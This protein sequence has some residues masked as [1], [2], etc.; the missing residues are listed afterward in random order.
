MFIPTSMHLNTFILH[1]KFN[2]CLIKYNMNIPFI[3]SFDKE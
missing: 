3:L 1:I 2:H